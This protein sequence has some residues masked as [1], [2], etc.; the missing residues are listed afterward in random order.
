M[1]IKPYDIESFIKNIQ[2]DTTQKLIILYGQDLGLIEE[3]T[4]ILIKRFFINRIL[5][6]NVNINISLKMIVY[7]LSRKE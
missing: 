4:K 7:L 6:I 1:I 2:S 5:G 3:R